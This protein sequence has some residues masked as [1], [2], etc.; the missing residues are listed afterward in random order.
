MKGLFSTAL[1]VLTA[2]LLSASLCAQQKDT[3]SGEHIFSS[4]C[5]ACH[6]ADGRGGERAPDI[7]TRR[8]VISLTD[9]DIEAIVKKGIPGAGMPP[10]GYMG[11]QKVSDVVAFLRTLQ[12]KVA[13]EK[14]VGDPQAGRTL[15]YGKAECSKCHMVQGEGGFTGTDL[16]TYGSGTS[17]AR[18]HSAIV[19]PDQNLQPTSKVVKIRTLSGQNISGLLRSEDN[20]NIALQTEDGRFHMYSKAKLASIDHTSHS[21]M[22]RDYESKLS[23]KEIDDLVSFLITTASTSNASERPAKKGRR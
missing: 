5:A 6:G 19:D 15:F 3:A 9:V 2:S 12:G 20:F 14:V 22:P 7:A 1:L 17:A 13:G 10:F 23:S 4:S 21:T 8:N 18:I 11:D 16:S